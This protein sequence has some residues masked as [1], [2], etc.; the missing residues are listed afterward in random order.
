LADLK[1]AGI[2]PGARIS[3][4]HQRGRI[5]VVQEG[6]TEGLAMDHDLAAHLF[7]QR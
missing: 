4:E 6:A 1:H 2:I 3:A 5:L 7:V